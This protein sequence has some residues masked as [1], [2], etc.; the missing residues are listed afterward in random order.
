MIR[1][2]PI[3]RPSH[4]TS[5]SALLARYEWL[6]RRQSPQG[7]ETWLNWAIRLEAST[8]KGGRVYIGTVQMT[9]GEDATALLAYELGS[10]YRGA[11]YAT[12]ACQTVM[13]EVVEV[14]KVR[15]IQAHVDTRN[16]RSI[17]LLERL[18]FASD[19]AHS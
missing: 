4:R 13:R 11:G 3:S 12:E 16:E 17:L 2:T 10:A 1:C 8:L 9:I 6:A 15:E 19:D 7:D 18:G 5:H 14:Y